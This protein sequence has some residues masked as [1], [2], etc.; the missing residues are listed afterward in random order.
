MVTVLFLLVS[1]MPSHN[2][3]NS[4][5]TGAEQGVRTLG[6]VITDKAQKQN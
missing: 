3:I 2:K 4:S 6:L 1:L 5:D